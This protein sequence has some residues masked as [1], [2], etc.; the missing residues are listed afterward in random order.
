MQF[1][2]HTDR[3]TRVAAE[4]VNLLTAGQAR[5]RDYQPPSGSRLIGEVSRTLGDAGTRRDVTTDEAAG[6]EAVASVLRDV[7]VAVSAGDIDTAARTVNQMLTFSGARPELERHDGSGW[8]LHYTSADRTM[9]NGRAAGCAASLA[10]VLGGPLYDRLGVCTAPHCD[11]VY[12][13]I[14]RNGTRRFC[15]TAC[16]NRVKTAAFRARQAGTITAGPASRDIPADAIRPS[17]S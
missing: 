11:R 15:S 12:V 5:G 9:V 1:N 16:Q 14:S 4:L 2:S 10:V 3:V 8:H 13:D 17:R 7:F 6:I